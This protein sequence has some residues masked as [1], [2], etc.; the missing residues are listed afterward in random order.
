VR[1]CDYPALAVGDVCWC[2]HDTTIYVVEISEIKTLDSTIDGGDPLVFYHVTTKQRYDPFWCLDKPIT[3]HRNSLFKFPDEKE[4]L[5]EE[6]EHVLRRFKDWNGAL[7]ISTEARV[8]VVNGVRLVD[9]EP[10]L[11][12]PELGTWDV[13]YVDD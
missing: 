5:R 9:A 13:E 12:K 7:D 3:Q 11:K 2:L 4:R 1:N 8:E 6:I 10:T